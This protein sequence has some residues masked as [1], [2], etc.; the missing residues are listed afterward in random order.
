MVE[1]ERN[2]Q[3]A[4]GRVMGSVHAPQSLRAQIQL[5]LANT[6]SNAANAVSQESPVAGR[7]E[8][9]GAFR[10]VRTR[11]AWR[12]F[13]A[14][15]RANILAVAAV[16]ALIVGAVLFGIYGR[17]IDDVPAQRP[18]DVVG[19]VAVFADTEHTECTTD[20]EHVQQESTWR[21]LAE[22]EVGMTELLATRVRAF[23]LADLGYEFVGAGR[24]DAPLDK[25]P[26]GHMI[27]RKI[28]NGV[29]GPMV[30]IFVAPV[31]GCCKSVCANLLPGEWQAAKAASCK[32]RVLYS[33]DGKL[34]YFL[35]CCD[36]RDLA[37]VGRAITAAQASSR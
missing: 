13:D 11:S 8:S 25:Q 2:L 1:G 21:T 6:P 4:I 15:Q 30:S 34:L 22:T 7:I 17:S 3:H 31:R 18:V 12:L 26:S 36:E 23:N 35:V 27:Y 28:V 33:T 10:A 24:C 29:P 32:R 19:N 5:T 14:P 37:G 16:L 20:K 9:A